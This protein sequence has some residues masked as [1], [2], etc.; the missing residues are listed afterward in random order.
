MK[1]TEELNPELAHQ[2]HEIAQDVQQSEDQE[3]STLNHTD[4]QESLSEGYQQK[5]S[6]KKRQWL[7]P[8]TSRA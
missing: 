3:R 5:T 8:P 2:A 7:Y 4:S 6:R 1:E